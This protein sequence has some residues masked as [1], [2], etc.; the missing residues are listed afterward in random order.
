MFKKYLAEFLGTFFIVL[1]GCGAIVIN[2]QYNGVITHLG[3]SIIFGVIVCLVIYAFS[4]QSTHFNPAVSIALFLSKKL[5]LK[6]L[7][8]F[9]IFQISGVIVASIILHFIFPSN[10]LIG[11]TQ[12]NG[13]WLLSFGLEFILTFILLT[14]IFIL[15][16]YPTKYAGLLIGLLIFLEAYFAGPICGASMN[17]ARSIGPAIV[18]GHLNYLWLYIIAPTMGAISALYI[19]NFIIK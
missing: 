6:H 12:P 2:Q 4:K 19:R 15:D 11:T 1:I 14:L 16:K 8:A 9:I 17:P 10:Q 18:S 3:I 7:I 5:S 13:Y